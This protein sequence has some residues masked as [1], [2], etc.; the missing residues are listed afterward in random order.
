M[1][2]SPLLLA[3]LVATGCLGPMPKP[4]T[5]G[6]GDPYQGT[7]E[8]IFV[9]DSRTDWDIHEGATLISAEHALEASGD[10]EYEL[11]R[12]AMKA[13]NAMLYEE[14]RA[15]RR[16]GYLMMGGGTA[17]FVLGT[18]AR[19]LVTADNSSLLGAMVGNVLMY[20]GAGGVAYGY[21]G[22]RKRPPYVPWRIPSALDRPAYIRRFTEEYNDKLAERAPQ[23]KPARP[24]GPLRP[25]PGLPRPT[26]SPMPRPRGGR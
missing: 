18:V 13:H 4:P 15:H 24:E 2:S 22:A 17:L 9:K 5:A 16:R 8:T 19:Y 21:Y 25:P 6:Y 26:K 3:T 1:R 20:G 11:R 14:A 10:P 23:L 12:Q 7:G